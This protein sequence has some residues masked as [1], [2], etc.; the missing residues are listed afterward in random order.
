[1]KALVR[2][3]SRSVQ[4]YPW[5]T[6]V[7]VLV[8]GFGLASFNR[9]AVQADANDGFAPEAEALDAAE[10]VGD[11]FGEESTGTVMQIIVSGDDVISG[12]GLDAV[13]QVTASIFA[14][15]LAVD[16]QSANGQP[17]VVSFLAPVQGFG[18][19]GPTVQVSVRSSAGDVFT[20][21]GLAAVQQIQGAGFG[22]FAA[23]LPQDGTPPVSSFLLPVESA[24]AQGFAPPEL[25]TEAIKQTYIESIPNLPPEVQPI[26]GFLAAND[27]DLSVPS[28]SAGLVSFTLTEPLTAEEEAA[29]TAAVGGAQLADG[30]SATVL[31]ANPSED[32]FKSVYRERSA[33]IPIEQSGLVENLLSDDKDL[34]APSASSGLMLVFLNATDQA[35]SEA[36]TAFAERQQALVDDINALTLPE[37]FTASGFS[38]DLI[39]AS[40]DDGTAEIARMFGLA[41]LIIVVI[42]M[43]NY[44]RRLSGSYSVLRSS[45]RMLATMA[46][47]MFAIIM[48][49]GIMQGIGVLLGP[50]YLGIIGDFNQIVQILPILLI[51]LGV[52]YGIHMTSRYQEEFGSGR[53]TAE[54]TETA[55][56]T[57][58]V[59][60]VLATAT[61]AV[62]FLTNLV[63][64][65]PALKD[66][67]ILAAVGIVVSF[68]L[69]LTLVPAVRYLLDRGG[70]KA[71]RLHQQDF[72]GDEARGSAIGSMIAG[73][74]GGASVY[75]LSAMI[76]SGIR[77][78]NYG[79][80]FEM[81]SLLTFAAIGAVVGII[82]IF[83][84][85]IVAPTGILAEKAP[86]PV[87]IVALIIGVV[88]YIGFQQLETKFSFT[89][90]LP[91]DNPLL[92][93]IDTLEAEFGGGFGE[94][95]S[96]LI[97]G[98]VASV[99]VHNAQ[100][101]A[102]SNLVD[103]DDIV[104][105]GS[106]PAADSPLSV[107]GGLLDPSAPTYDGSVAA[108]AAA[109]TLFPDL[110][111]PAGADLTDLY[112]AAA[113]AAPEA[114]GSVIHVSD[115]GTYDAALWTINTQAGDS[116]AGELNDN[117]DVAFA[118]V[119]SAGGSAIPTSQSIIGDV[120]VKSLQSSQVSSLWITLAAATL[121]LILNFWIESRRWFLGVI[122]MLPVVLVVLATF[123]TMAL[124]GIP[125][126][127]VTATISALA[128]GIAVP[129]TI[130]ITHRFQ[131]DRLRYDTT[132][133][134]IRSTTLHTGGALA[135]SALTTMAGF[136]SLVTSNLTP[137]Q[138]FGAVTFYAIAYAL[139]FSLLVLPSM[140]VLWDR[141]HRSRGED[142]VDEERLHKALGV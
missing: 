49:I 134:A 30:Y 112:A 61:T 82:V 37:G 81:N 41:A 142:T 110:S 90:F 78:L 91:S 26:L 132:E 45:R 67:G 64:P 43:F 117:L 27:A 129:Y 70:E 54:A 75:A 5:V 136:G 94:T 58:G 71:D 88:G 103:V 16:L 29:F 66:F 31:P 84:P 138:Q 35:D 122:T 33:F 101:E 74:V 73:A 87:V 126:G 68:V 120:V 6:V 89:D 92:A 104:L 13:N 20:A 111:A 36:Y 125:F 86:V 2:L 109:A 39:F 50:K 12:D 25:P 72:A 65:I 116:R 141:W 18:D 1:M 44:W 77:D 51:G 42:L 60:L 28:A 85:K 139:L 93:T 107:L 135:G 119:D 80:V 7:L 99:E 8:V 19:Q 140:L 83:L 4:R 40:G 3:L 48:A 113:A 96:V 131:E 34:E 95:T 46:L 14:S 38:F 62:G 10:R 69:M 47:T 118:S 53:S 115:D 59:A 108:E 137:F 124:T 56:R 79:D 100:V 9:E 105:F 22:V 52:D 106:F 127:P 76:E 11:L 98:D 24:I 114:F 97:E 133:E 21:E 17:P 15:E 102:L 55:I 123:G 130:H 57:V 32:V 121:L 23:K 63:S 128:I